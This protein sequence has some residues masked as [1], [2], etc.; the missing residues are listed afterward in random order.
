MTHQSTKIT[1]V[2]FS[3]PT[4]PATILRVPGVP[5]PGPAHQALFAAARR[6]DPGRAFVTGPGSTATAL[7]A[8]QAGAAV[9]C[10][11]DSA[12]EARALA[13]TFEAAGLPA[14]RCV[15][16]ATFEGLT[17]AHYDQALIHLPRGRDRQTEALQLAAALLRERGRLTFVGAKNE[18]VKGA[19][20]QAQAIFGHAGVVARKGGYHAGLA[21]RPAGPCPMPTV[22]YETHEVT[23]DGQPTYVVSAPGVF[24]GAQLDDGAA[25]LIAGMHV[26]PGTPA[27]DLGCGTGLVGLAALRRGASA[28]LVDVSARAVASTR[29]TLAANGYPAAPVHLGCGAGPLDAGS[30]DAVLTN[31]PFHQGHGVDFEVAQWFVREAA[32][33]LRRGGT[34]SLVAN[35]FL[36]PYESWLKAHFIQVDVAWESPRFKVWTGVKGT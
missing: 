35:A 1:T 21:Q 15:L 20:Q 17:P 24:A 34:I 7:W 26:I 32:R 8:A 5:A 4:G 27:L 31:P 33:V 2:A 36:H 22:T 9:T 13:L 25:A 30:V 6:I 16:Q 12:A 14:P 18:G 3:L 19:V 29:R 11:T 23:V 28:T 10:W